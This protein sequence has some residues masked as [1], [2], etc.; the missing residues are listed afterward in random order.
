MKTIWYKQLVAP[1]FSFRVTAS[2]SLP[3]SDS[4]STGALCHPGAVPGPAGEH[5][6][7]VHHRLLYGERAQ[8]LLVADGVV[9]VVVAGDAVLLPVDLRRRHA[10]DPVKEWGRRTQISFNV[11]RC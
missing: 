4:E 8:P 9:G 6:A 10:G 2:I 3:T 1:V 11:G 7:V 5:A